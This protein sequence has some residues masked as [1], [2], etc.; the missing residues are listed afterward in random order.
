MN[1]TRLLHLVDMATRGA[2]PQSPRVGRGFR[3]PLRDFLLADA[4]EPTH[5]GRAY[6]VERTAEW[7]ARSPDRSS[8]FSCSGWA[9]ASE[10][11]SSSVWFP[12]SVRCSPYFASRGSEQD[13]EAH[14]HRLCDPDGYRPGRCARCGHGVLHVHCYPERRSSTSRSL[15]GRF[16]DLREQRFRVS[17]RTALLDADREQ[18][19]RILVVD[20][21]C[22]V[23]LTIT[24]SLLRRHRLDRP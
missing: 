10:L 8:P 23:L 24:R 14:E 13:L 12:R 17:R 9:S 20:A 5:F 18:H 16:Y 15:R 7:S 21:R 4:V 2:S 1:F 3:S 22:V 19:V 6:G 11:W